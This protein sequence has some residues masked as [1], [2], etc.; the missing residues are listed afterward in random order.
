MIPIK[1]MTQPD[2]VTCGPTSLHAVYQYFGEK[3]TLNRVIKEV[4]YLEGGGTLAVLLGCHALQRGYEAEV[5]SYNLQVLDPSWFAAGRTDVLKK[6]KLQLQ[7]KKNKKLQYAIRSYMK[8][9]KLG[10]KIRTQD[11]TPHLLRSYFERG[12]PIL[13]GLSATYLYRTMREY[14][15]PNNMTIYDDIKGHPSGHFVVLSGYNQK[16]KRVIV[17]DPYKANP[18]SNDNYYSVKASRLINAIMLGAGTYDANLLIIH[19]KGVNSKSPL[20]D[21]S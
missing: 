20:C 13:S 7:Y 6:L 10:G 11:P 12:L 5:F 4:S 9:L 8:F 19:P 15:G 1:I 3:I 21:Q 14:T 2:D 17:A 16:N 18:V